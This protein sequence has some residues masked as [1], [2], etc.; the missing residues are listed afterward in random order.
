MF[1]DMITTHA[2]GMITAP[3]QRHRPVRTSQP[4]AEQLLAPDLAAT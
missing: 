1:H 2:G 3:S 4:L